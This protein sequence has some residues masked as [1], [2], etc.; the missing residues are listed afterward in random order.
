MRHMW[1]CF[2]ECTSIRPT[3]KR[4]KQHHEYFV[5]VTL[6]YIY[7]HVFKR[8]YERATKWGGSEWT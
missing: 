8:E 1:F 5:H 3:K 2:I 6:N 7:G 4:N